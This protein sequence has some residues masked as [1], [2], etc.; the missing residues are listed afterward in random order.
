MVTGG[1][2]V[3]TGG[4]TVTVDSGHLIVVHICI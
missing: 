1:P 3:I 4:T 2:S